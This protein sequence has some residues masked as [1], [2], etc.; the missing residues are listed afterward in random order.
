MQENIDET[1]KRIVQHE[2]AP[3]KIV[4]LHSEEAEDADGDPILRIMVIYEAEQN[5]LDPYK[6]LGL[7]EHLRVPL[8][9][10][11]VDRFPILSFMIPDEVE[12]LEA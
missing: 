6:V 4:D 5:R 7:V 2:L 10:L 8:R 11:P 12:A 3:A 1:L 9:T